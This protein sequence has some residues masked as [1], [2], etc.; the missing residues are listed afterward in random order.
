MTDKRTVAIM[1]AILMAPI[2]AKAAEGDDS[3]FQAVRSG[4]VIDDSVEQARRL[5]DEANR[6]DGE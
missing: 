4:R 3:C 6:E 2:V 5:M 1:A